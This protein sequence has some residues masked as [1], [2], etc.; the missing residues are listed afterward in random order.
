MRM[1]TRKFGLFAAVICVCL[2]AQAMAADIYVSIDRGKNKNGGGTIEKPYKNIEWAIEKANPGDVIHIAA[3]H[4]P[5]IAGK[6]HWVVE[7]NNLTFLAGYKDDF[8]ERNPFTHVTLLA[9]DDSDKNKTKRWPGPEIEAIK[10]G[11]AKFAQALGGITIDGFTMDGGPRNTYFDNE[12][13]K[14]MITHDTPEDCLM[15]ICVHTG[16]KAIV[17]NCTFLNPGRLTCMI[18]QAKAEASVEVANCLLLNA[19]RHSIDIQTK[20]DKKGGR[21]DFSFHHN[22]VVFSWEVAKANGS[23]VYVR[24]YAN[25]KVYNNIIAWCDK[26]AL[27]NAY[28]EKKLNERGVPVETGLPN[29]EIEFDNNLIYACKGGIYGWVAKGQSGI[30]ATTDLGELEDTSLASAED[31]EFGDPEF[32]YNQ[33]WMTEFLN[34]DTAAEGEIPVDLVNR[35]RSRLGLPL[36]APAGA[37]K[38]GFCM[39]Y[40]LEDVLKFRAPASEAESDD[41]RGASMTVMQ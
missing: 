25:A 8:S 30:L 10:D 14:S 32:V 9:W 19:C 38:Q 40:P 20:L 27:C 36:Q 35:F 17:R 29:E 41:P 21:A 22:T 7:K 24:N 31:N 5:G 33:A 12:Q 34:R 18:I 16:S 15:H 37:N 13:N 23:G 6:G 39:R 4:Y 2:V 26:F 1:T 11:D 28:Y 3:G